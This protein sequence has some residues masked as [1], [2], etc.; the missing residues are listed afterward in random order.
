VGLF[1]D[2][3]LCAIHAKRYVPH[4]VTVQ[5]HLWQTAGV[6]RRP[7]SCT[8]QSAPI[9]HSSHAVRQR[10]QGLAGAA[11][12]SRYGGTCHSLCG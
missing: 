9:C 2:T 7:V 12:N 3:N 8:L 1:E 10:G 5:P 6:P 4:T 11:V